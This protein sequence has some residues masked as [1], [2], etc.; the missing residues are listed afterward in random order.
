MRHDVSVFGPIGWS[1][2]PARAPSRSASWLKRRLM[3]LPRGADRENRGMPIL[4]QHELTVL[5]GAYLV[6]ALPVGSLALASRMSPLYRISRTYL[7]RWWSRGALVVVAACL[8]AN[9]LKSF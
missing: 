9:V 2:R 1:W 5:V 8:A 3:G 6:A 4:L 7:C